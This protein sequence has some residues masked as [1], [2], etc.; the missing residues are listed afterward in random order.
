[1]ADVN[2]TRLKAFYSEDFLPAPGVEVQFQT[3]NAIEYAAHH[4][5]RISRNLDRIIE[6]LE[7]RPIDGGRF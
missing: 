7:K 4:L 2:K 1:M 5:G 6:L 3:I